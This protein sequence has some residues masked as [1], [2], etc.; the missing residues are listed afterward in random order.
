MQCSLETTPGILL[1]NRSVPLPADFLSLLSADGRMETFSY[2]SC[3]DRAV[4]FAREFARTSAVGSRVAILLDHSLDL[5][6]SFLGALLGGFVPAVFPPP[7]PKLAASDYRQVLENLILD[8][9]PAVVTVEPRYSSLAPI[10]PS[11]RV[12]VP[13]PDAWVEPGFVPVPAGDPNEIAFLQYSSGTSGRRKGVAISHAA[14]LWQVRAYREALGM[15]RLDRIVSWLPLYHDMGLVACCLL[16]FLAGHPLVAM[17]P[18]DWVKRPLTLLDAI[19]AHR[20][21]WCWLP[22]FAFSFLAKSKR[23]RANWDL[24]SMRGWINCSEPLTAESMEGFL[25]AFAPHGVRPEK[26]V[27]CYAMAETT[28]A[29]TQA[30]PGADSHRFVRIRGTSFAPESILQPA[31]A[32]EPGARVLAS[33]GT[34]LPETEIQI[35]DQAGATHSEEGFFGEIAVRSPSLFSGYDNAAKLCSTGLRDVFFRTGDLGFLMNGHLFVAGRKKDLIIVQGKNILPQDVEEAVSSVEAVI[36][37]RCVAFGVF[38][39]AEGTE[40]LV[41]LAETR[42]QDRSGR[43]ALVQRIRQT[44]LLAADVAASDVM[45]VPHLWLAK[46]SSGKIS[47]GKNRERYLESLADS[48]EHS[49][50]GAMGR[51][52]V[53][54]ASG[55]ESMIDRVV[56][57][58]APGLMDADLEQVRLITEGWL[59]SLGVAGLIVRLEEETGI[60]FDLCEVADLQTFDTISSIRAL[61]DPRRNRSNPTAAGRIQ[62]R[63]MD[64]IRAVKTSIYQGSARDFDLIVLGSSRCHFLHAATA[65]QF[66]FKSFNFSVDS[67]KAED[68][69]CMLRLVL[70]QNRVTPRWVFVGLDVETFSEAAEI[71]PSLIGCAAL[72]KYLEDAVP[73]PTPALSL[74]TRQDEFWQVFRRGINETLGFAFARGTGDFIYQGYD[75]QAPPLR[76]ADGADRNAVYY[77]RMEGFPKLSSARLK[78]LDEIGRLC[79]ERGIRRCYFLSTAHGA[80]IRF[81]SEHTVFR[82]RCDELRQAIEKSPFAPDAFH[83]F[84]IASSFGGDAEDF[85]NGAHVGPHNARRLFERL[86]EQTA[87]PRGGFE[88]QPKPVADDVRKL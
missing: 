46:S 17:S 81:L 53:G 1:G 51:E 18:F 74:E 10:L 26:V 28:F 30:R 34:P 6:A 57:A 45:L 44:V 31:V 40:R 86:L 22:N 4:Y 71:A 5:Y 70:D 66:G 3:Y 63:H 78:W 49:G 35:L 61:V 55:A 80:L 76:I 60:T 59:D 83:D 73:G 37:G 41:V 48:R 47:R 54:D 64:E 24:T 82:Q 16:P 9:A 29:I 39:P 67:G 50:A 72:A 84:S 65:A 85:I 25:T 14:L 77:R 8:T 12:L 23:A 15:N 32:N 62:L 33:S 58:Q 56:R 42:E 88:G 87:N 2:A 21:Q 11:I 69:Y 52:F 13:E 75:S 27:G 68:F 20:A 7:S 43:L 36:P 38:A 79:Q 19:H